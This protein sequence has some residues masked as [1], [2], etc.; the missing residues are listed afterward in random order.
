VTFV[1][2]QFDDHHLANGRSFPSPIVTNDDLVSRIGVYIPAACAVQSMVS[3]VCKE[4]TVN[5]KTKIHD[6]P[7]Y[8]FLHRKK[9]GRKNTAAV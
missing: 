9:R 2:N 1:P 6:L 5:R 3:G 4:N 7:W 8:L